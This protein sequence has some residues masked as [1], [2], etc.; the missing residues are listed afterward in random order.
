MTETMDDEHVLCMF[1]SI[2]R[3]AG[4]SHIGAEPPECIK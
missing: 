3:Q 4:G 1:I 2:D